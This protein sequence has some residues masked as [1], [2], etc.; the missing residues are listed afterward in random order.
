VLVE[1]QEKGLDI[2][3]DTYA[4]KALILPHSQDMIEEKYPFVLV[5][6]HSHRHNHRTRREVELVASKARAHAARISHA[7]RKPRFHHAGP[8]SPHTPPSQLPEKR[9]ASIAC[10]QL[11][12]SLHEMKIFT[13]HDPFTSYPGSKLPALCRDIMDYGTSKTKNIIFSHTHLIAL[14]SIRYRILSNIW[15]A[16]TTRALPAEDG[17]AKKRKYCAGSLPRHPVI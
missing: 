5:N 2:D 4:H 9:L 13:G 7:R 15:P 3:H 11:S 12:R 1:A 8:K 14:D 10:A 6:G 16:T 17:M